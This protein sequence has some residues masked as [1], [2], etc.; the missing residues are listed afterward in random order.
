MFPNQFPAHK[1]R[2][3]DVYCQRIKRKELGT[4]DIFHLPSI[5]SYEPSVNT[6]GPY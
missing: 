1:S 3:L 2:K 4:V 5:E 6:L